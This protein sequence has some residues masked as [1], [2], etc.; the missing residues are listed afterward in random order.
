MVLLNTFIGGNSSRPSDNTGLSV[1]S[2]ERATNIPAT[3]HFPY[4]YNKC[5]KRFHH[6]PFVSH[7]VRVRDGLLVDYRNLPG[8]S[9]V[10]DLDGERAA[11]GHVHA[12]VGQTL[13]H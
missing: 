6:Y 13:G 11:V 1:F 2:Q 5:N 7:D 9:V 12:D 8:G 4:Q 3:E 10:R